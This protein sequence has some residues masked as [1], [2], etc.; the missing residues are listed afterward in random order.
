[1][2]DAIDDTEL[3]RSR[4][5]GSF[6]C[7][8]D[9]GGG[10]ADDAPKFVLV[11]LVAVDSDWADDA[12]KVVLVADLDWADAALRVVSVVGLLAD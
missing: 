2:V 6:V 12:P 11:T 4:G 7:W 10:L 5:V 3:D 8:S 9:A 1:M